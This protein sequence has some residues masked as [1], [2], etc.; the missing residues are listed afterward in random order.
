LVVQTVSEAMK[1][2]KDDHF[3]ALD[4][5]GG[6]L[7]SEGAYRELVVAGTMGI[8]GRGEIGGQCAELAV[9]GL[10][11]AAGQ[12]LKSRPL[13][14]AAGLRTAGRDSDSETGCSL[15]GT[16]FALVYKN[17]SSLHETH[18]QKDVCCKRSLKSA[19][20]VRIMTTTSPPRSPGG[21][22]QPAQPRAL[23]R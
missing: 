14:Q 1:E 20:A 21:R 6:D 9:D 12:F 13:S 16:E 17:C 3:H 5:P 8:V 11:D 18:P 2:A 15:E 7:V 23:L 22:P 19:L 4:R 10:V